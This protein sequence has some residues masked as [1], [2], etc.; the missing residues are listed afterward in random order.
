M[1]QWISVLISTVALIASGMSLYFTWKDQK[2]RE[3]N[4]LT[5]SMMCCSDAPANIGDV[6]IDKISFSVDTYWKLTI[7][8]VSDRPLSVIRIT[9][10][11]KYGYRGSFGSA[12]NGVV[13]NYDSQPSDNPEYIQPGEARTFV[14]R[15]SS[16]LPSSVK[17]FVSKCRN[18]EISLQALETCMVSLGSD[19]YGNMVSEVKYKIT[20][21][22][23][24]R[25]ETTFHNPKFYVEIITGRGNKFFH[26]FSRYPGFEVFYQ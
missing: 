20:S 17:D 2:A 8:N 24:M 11:E 18:K 4:L 22:K 5:E 21:L 3:E 14:L 1:R 15:I 7:S 13:A 10:H 19:L 25:S 23:E 12:R 16:Y 6:P 9:P 26:E